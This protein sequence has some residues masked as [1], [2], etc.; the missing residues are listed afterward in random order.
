[1][2][3]NQA[4]K[5]ADG[6][7]AL[8]LAGLVAAAVM[9]VSI[10]A[11]RFTSRSELK[12]T[13]QTRIQYA[14]REVIETAGFKLINQI[15]EPWKPN[16]TLDEI[17][18]IY[19]QAGYRALEK[20]ELTL[21]DPR[22]TDRQRLASM[23]MK[24]MLLQYEGEAKQAFETLQQIRAE[25]E[26]TPKTAQ[27]MLY[28]VVFLQGIAGLRRGE[29][30]NCILCRCESS[31]IIP[32]STAAIHVNPEGSRLAIHHFTEY[33][34]QFPDDLEARRLLNVAHM[35]LGEH[36]DQ[37]TPEYLVSMD[38][39]QKQ[40]TSIGKFRDIGHKI[41][42]NSLNQAGGA[43]MDDF[44]ND[45]LLDIVTSTFDK[46]GPMYFYRNNGSGTF[47][48]W[49]AEADVTDQPGGVN[50]T[51]T[52]FN[53]DGFLDIFVIRGAWLGRPV[54]SSLLRSNQDGTFT[55]ITEEAGLLTP[56]N[57]IAA[58]WADYD[59][60]GLTDLFV[61]CERQPSRLYRNLGN[62]KFLEVSSEAGVASRHLDCKG[63]AWIDIDNDGYEDLFLT[64]LTQDSKSKLF[65]NNRDGTFSEQG[66]S[67]G[68]DGPQTGF[69][70]WS[71]D[72]DND[73]WLDLFATSY[74][75]TVADV[76]RGLQGV[77]HNQPSGRLY[78]NQQG[79]GFVNLAKE[80]GL[81]GC[82]ATMG[83]NF[84]DFDNDGF[85]DFY[86]GTGDPDISMLVPN[87]MFKNMAGKRFSEITA[88][89]GTGHLQKGHSVA[90]GDGDR[91]GNVDLFIEMG[92]A[93]NGDKYHNIMFQNPGH[94]NQFLIVK[95]IGT[96]T[97]RAAIGARIKVVT[98]GPTPLTIHR[99]VSSGSSFGANSLQQTLGL[100]KA[101]KVALWEIEW[102]AS[103]TK[104]V[105]HDVKVNQAIEITE[106]QDRYRVL[107]YS[108]IPIPKD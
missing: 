4:A 100:A 87:R 29:N 107:N 23:F 27:E 89:S 83:S 79:K 84:A 103:G 59:N 10:I 65:R 47:D 81:D 93:V 19:D 11:W 95:L 80:A 58:K 45:G 104:Q 26:K 37:V 53:N 2:V 101:A 24:V 105:F 69:S 72:Y 42:V 46:T 67:L 43:I 13:P 60:D 71:F 106:L 75:R 64:Y 92:G 90:C 8:L 85:L 22:A 17:L 30:E 39:F 102:P 98:A 57:S 54:R 94:D 108:A 61:C 34:E 1:M 68:I 18:E 91:D 88:S 70:C 76:V 74:N 16:A 77:P 49:L 31:C 25:I 15:V 82:Y 7:A 21:K 51:Q 6:A 14:P 96:K 78:H 86:L 97:N 33:L 41:G 73:G 62:D 40:E 28:T 66:K 20:L 55:D 9:V 99:H 50:V 52:D 32:I 56:V 35:T 38:A 12:E 44:D 48:K 3:T 5:P 63:L 36:P